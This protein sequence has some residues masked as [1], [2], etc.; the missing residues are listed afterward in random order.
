MKPAA[1]GADLHNRPED[2]LQDRQ[3]AVGGEAHK[4]QLPEPRTNGSRAVASQER[5]SD[6][7]RN[8]HA[9]HDVLRALP[10]QYGV[11]SRACICV[12]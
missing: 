7:A 4:S 11:R 2:L 9:L 8:R 1:R 10:N 6:Q 5:D 12:A 3:Q